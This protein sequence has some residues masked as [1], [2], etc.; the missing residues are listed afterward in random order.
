MKILIIVN[1]L[2]YG[3]AEKQAVMD[4]NLFADDGHHVTFAYKKN[5]DLV[6]TLS[7]KVRL[8]RISHQFMPLASLQLLLHL[9][10]NKYD[11][12]HCHLFWA[13]MISMVPATLMKQHYV[14][15]EHGLG[16]WR[17][18]YHLAIIRKIYRF[19]AKVITPCRAV[20]NT[21]VERE[22]IDTK[23]VAVIYN[24]FESEQPLRSSQAAKRYS[25][26][27]GFNI[28]FVGRFSPVKRLDIFL[29]LAQDLKMSI[30]EFHFV[31]VGDGP[32]RQKILSE[33][34]KRNLNGYFCLPGFAAEPQSYYRKF[35]VFIL[36][37]ES[38][39]FSLALLEAAA[40]SVP[41]IAFDVGGNAEII[42]D[43]VTGYILPYCDV[44][45]LAEKIVFLYRNEDVRRSMG[46]SANEYASHRFSQSV[47]LEM[48]NNLYRNL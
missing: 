46:I 30:S 22:R 3:G 36:P 39:G 41:A 42:I 6:Q 21:I 27:D 12:I 18:W 44:E 4:A 15:N 14:F 9:S 40:A 33:L 7:K 1:A 47:R 24:S 11:V 17:R 13:A 5:G 25:K 43:D 26:A 37:S 19:S 20:M 16:N 8:F 35:D 29:S 23:K 34:N 45:L 38:E 48:L 2:T 31:L 32:E 10:Q 28:G